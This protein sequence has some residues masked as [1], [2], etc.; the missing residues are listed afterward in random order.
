MHHWMV[1]LVVL[2]CA[3][4]SSAKTLEEV[5]KAVVE[6]MERHKS[7]RGGVEMIQNV[8]TSILKSKTSARGAFEMKKYPE[9]TYRSRIEMKGKM[10]MDVM[11]TVQEQPM[12][13]LAIDDGQ[14]QH[15]LMVTG[16]RSHAI[17][18]R[19]DPNNVFGGKQF[20]EL[21]REKSTLKLLPDERIDDADCYVIEATPKQPLPMFARVVTYIQKQ[22]GVARKMSIFDKQGKETMTIKTSDIR[23]DVDIPDER[24]VFKVPKGVI[25]QDMTRTA[26]RPASRPASRGAGR[27]NAGE[28]VPDLET[29]LKRFQEQKQQ[30]RGPAEKQ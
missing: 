19:R 22:T 7:I 25:M 1:S 17:K 9:G 16:Q 3:V 15:T 6:A 21:Q 13:M 24:F 18:G 27:G 14:Y 20:F 29:I 4:P 23:L 30:R 2:A 12:E 11:G 26:T 8:D 10:S 28:E 5:E